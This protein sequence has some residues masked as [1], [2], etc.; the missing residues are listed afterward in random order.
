MTVRRR[1]TALTVVGALF[2]AIALFA[3]APESLRSSRRAAPGPSRIVILFDVD[4]LRADRLGMYGY[5]RP[6]S[7]HLDKVL[8]D[9]LV[10]D[11]AVTSAGWT[12]PAHAS[13]F[14]SRTVAAHGVRSAGQKVPES[15]PLLAEVLSRS[16]VL[17][18][19]IQSGG[20]VDAGFG[21]WRGFRNYIYSTD[22]AAL[23]VR[24]AL[25]LVDQAGSEPLFLFL[26]T[27]QVH[28]YQGTERGARAVFGSTN[29]LGPRW[30]E[31]FGE[32]ESA[33]G[34]Y[35]EEQVGAW[36]SARYDAAIRETDESVGELVDG[37]K[38]RGLWDRT[39]FILTSD[40]G[41]ELDE[42]PVQVAG[43]APARGHTIPYLYEE[44][45]RIPLALRAPWRKDLRGRIA[46]PVS[47]LDV[48]PTVLDLFDVP[49]PASMTGEPLGKHMSDGRTVVSE[50]S[51]YGAL[52]LLEGNHKVIVR[53]GFR[54]R[55]WETGQML[56]ALPAEECFD[57]GN[58]PK[59]L[60]GTACTEP[61]AVRLRGEAERMV[62]SSF[63]G[64][65][66]FRAEPRGGPCRLDVAA[67]GG[68]DVRFFGEP[69]DARI[70]H[71]GGGERI[72]LGG[73]AGP[74]WVAIRALGD[75]K[76]V[77]LEVSGC[78]DVRTAAG[79]RLSSV[80]ETG[81]SELLWRGT[82]GLPEG[83]VLFSVRPGAR[84]PEEYAYYPPELTA[85][86]KSLGYVSS[87]EKTKAAPRPAGR[88]ETGTI[89]PP[90]RIRV[91]VA[92]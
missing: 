45:I 38:A 60:H 10:A 22:P 54:A 71:A 50:A 79:E 26:H 84:A 57:L 56:D 25:R 16:G 15:V 75:E 83:S 53:P 68:P 43:S 39:A 9:G 36:L 44:H 61:W 85:R 12:L 21:F 67:A 91:S 55:H 17:C 6:T 78:G 63:P 14:S 35:G 87:G 34:L 7:P 51:P 66:V 33:V 11:H 4:M 13:I 23:K 86:L 8:A 81:W 76:A 89:P 20:Y 69:P 62:A 59:E 80:R 52:A 41:Q 32:L 18:A 92:S 1:V 88:R 48:A 29:P 28:N 73:V 3:V 82:G 49:I 74:V 2:S 5:G 64:E 19:G 40:H 30:S 90:G 65:L 70:S 77:S 37:L 47:S 72:D 42:R 46:Q 27:V 31:P 58:D 24:G